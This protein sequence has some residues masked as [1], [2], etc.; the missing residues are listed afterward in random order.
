M[1]GL[2]GGVDQRLDGVAQHAAQQVGPEG[3]GQDAHLVGVEVDAAAAVAV[4]VQATDGHLRPKRQHTK[5]LVRTLFIRLHP[6]VII[7]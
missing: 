4:D 2:A 5:S 6:F 1:L 7:H 3:A